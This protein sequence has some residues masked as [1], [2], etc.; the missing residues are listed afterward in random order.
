MKKKKLF[1]L[2]IYLTKLY[3]IPFQNINY[4][5]FN[6]RVCESETNDFFIQILP[7]SPPFRLLSVPVTGAKPDFLSLL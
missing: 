4:K 6:Q 5:K 7:L 2:N 1:Y 3:D